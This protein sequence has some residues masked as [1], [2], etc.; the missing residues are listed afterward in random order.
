M[1]I[2]RAPS[3][4]SAGLASS[5]WLWLVVRRMFDDFGGHPGAIFQRAVRAGN[6]SEVEFVPIDMRWVPL[7]Y[8]CALVELCAEHW[9][10]K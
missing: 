4:A 2:E 6:L 1:T 3:A 10:P 9:S 5:T 7:E 8:A